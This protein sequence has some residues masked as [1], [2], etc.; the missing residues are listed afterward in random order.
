[1]V[2]GA[3]AV[4]WLTLAVAFL[5]LWGG[6]HAQMRAAEGIDEA[7]YADGLDERSLAEAA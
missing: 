3:L 1:M 7:A 4:A 2:I 6:L 5:V